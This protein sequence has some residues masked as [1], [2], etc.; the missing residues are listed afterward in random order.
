MKLIEKLQKRFD[1][2][3]TREVVDVALNFNEV[4][5]IIA[6]LKSSE[7]YEKAVE[8]NMMAAF[9]KVEKETQ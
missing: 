9:D 8:Q 5:Y 1:E 4:S 2:M 3:G 6:L 7:A